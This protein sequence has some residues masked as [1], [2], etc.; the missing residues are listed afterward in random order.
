MERDDL[1][2]EFSSKTSAFIRIIRG[3]LRDLLH[4]A[5]L[6]QVFSFALILERSQSCVP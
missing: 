1:K 6:L 5:K 4:T 2:I 3:L